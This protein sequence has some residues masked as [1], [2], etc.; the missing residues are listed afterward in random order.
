MNRYK[1]DIEIDGL[2]ICQAIGEFG[3]FIFLALWEIAAMW[4][5]IN[6]MPSVS[7]V[8]KVMMYGGS[9]ATQF[10]MLLLVAGSCFIFSTGVRVYCIVAAL[11]LTGVILY[12]TGGIIAYDA[13]KA[14]GKQ[15]LSTVAEEIR[16]NNQDAARTMNDGVL[17]AG[18]AGGKFKS[19][20]IQTATEGAQ[21][22]A[23]EMANSANQRIAELGTKTEEDARGKTY[24]S[25]SYMSGWMYAT[26]FGLGYFLVGIGILCLEGARK[27]A[28]RNHNGVPD[29]AEPESR[30]Y[31]PVRA[32]KFWA[33]RKQA[34]QLAI[35]QRQ[36]ALRAQEHLEQE[37]RRLQAQMA[38]PD[39]EQEPPKSQRLQ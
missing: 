8:F 3:L 31:D 30:K 9:L 4:T 10:A 27:L 39:L 13:A 35:S 26:L 20:N 11:A 25:E 14:Q 5:H 18:E 1:Y 19:R 6:A 34:N 33:D 29:W 32:Q 15:T 17:N 24:F 38:S 28:D 7:G 21:Q 37:Q 2:R 36:K 22:K 12:H 23:V 16:R